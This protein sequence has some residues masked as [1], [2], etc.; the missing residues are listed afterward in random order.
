MSTLVMV[1]RDGIGCMAAD[2]LVSFDGCGE[3]A[4]YLERPEKI[5]KRNEAC[6]GVVGL[7][8]HQ[9]VLDSLL[10]G[11]LE[12]PEFRSE[13]E[14]FEFSRGLHERLKNNYFLVPDT[15]DNAYESS[16]MTIGVLTRHGIFVL[17]HDRCVIQ[18][19]RFT[20]LGS[21]SRLA[22]GAMYAA[23]ELGLPADEVARLGV[24]AGIEF[25]PSSA[26]PITLERVEL[27]V[28]RSVCRPATAARGGR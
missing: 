9:H 3:S 20:A 14:V 27:A 2:T 7:R 10:R 26:A 16:R 4:R 18:Y 19:R 8:A 13:A 15:D 17:F 5:L 1:E 11:G 6:F 25:D 23:Y 12:V 28:G 21:G 24:E 22:L